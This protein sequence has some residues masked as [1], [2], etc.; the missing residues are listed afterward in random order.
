MADDPNAAGCFTG[1]ES[2]L[3]VTDAAALV[4]ES[5][6]ALLPGAGVPFD[7]S[8][9]QIDGIITSDEIYK[10]SNLP[11]GTEKSMDA[12]PEAT[13]ILAFLQPMMTAISTIMMVLGPVK[14]VID[15]VI[16]IINVICAIPNPIKIAQAMTPLFAALFKLASLFPA[17]AA[18]LIILQVA[19]TIILI[20][21]GIILVVLPKLLEI[22]ENVAL[23]TAED[24]FQSVQNS[25]FQKICGIVQ[26]ILNDLAILSPIQAIISLIASFAGGGI[27]N[28]CGIPTGG[29]DDTDC[30]DDC[31]QIVR[32][33]PAGRLT[34][35]PPN[36][37]SDTFDVTFSTALFSANLFGAS[38]LATVG[39]EVPMYRSI[40]ELLIS[41]SPIPSADE[42]LGSVLF[43]LQKFSPRGFTAAL[44][45]DLNPQ[46][47]RQ[48]PSTKTVEITFSS[49][50]RL[51]AGNSLLIMRSPADGR[52]DGEFKVSR[53]V[54]STVIAIVDD[55]PFEGL[56]SQAAET[57]AAGTTSVMRQFPLQSVR[58]DGLPGQT[59]TVVATLANRELCTLP[60]VSSG[61]SCNYFLIPREEVCQELVNTFAIGCLSSVA[62]SRGV[63]EDNLRPPT[64]TSPYTGNIRDLLGTEI[65]DIADFANDLREYTRSL[66]INPRVD[67]LTTFV[68][69]VQAEIDVW[70]DILERALCVSVDPVNSTFSVSNQTV[71]ISGSSKAIVSFQPRSIGP[72]G[73]QPSLVGLPSNISVQCLFTTTHGELSETVFDPATGTYSAELSAKTAGIA[74]LRAYFVTNDVCATAEQD[75][76]TRG[77]PPKVLQVRFVDGSL[78]PRRQDRQYLPSAGGRRR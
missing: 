2:P 75:G 26:D 21:G 42:P 51:S 30:C 68:P 54:S 50:H 41:P 5:F 7:P 31:P 20:L 62:A 29:S 48:I 58:L 60:P 46:S 44:D 35:T 73:G 14:L 15:I 12:H 22:A 78:R 33:S 53:I 71:D 47:I 70:K 16:A 24:A 66:L 18:L 34:I 39:S 9:P 77:F 59:R 1:D 25:G 69:K 27:A 55:R 4:L 37:G 61:D 19:K 8:K 63:F 23:I 10:I 76:P 45:I 74:D 43:D 17:A 13:D 52:F 11:G 56:T 36:S 6:S 65:P 72:D 32:N 38:D 57:F 40:E 67:P 3:P 49:P 64:S 28:I